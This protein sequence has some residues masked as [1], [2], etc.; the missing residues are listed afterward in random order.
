VLVD[1]ILLEVVSLQP[2]EPAAAATPQFSGSPAAPQPQSSN[3]PAIAWWILGA[4]TI[5]IALLAGL[6]L[7]IK[8]SW[9]AKSRALAPGSGEAALPAAPADLE[10]W[11][12][13]AAANAVTPR[14]EQSMSE[15]MGPELTEFAKQALVQGLYTQRNALLETQR[16]AQEA[17]AELEQRLLELQLPM[18]ERIRAYEARIAELEKELETRGAEMR[19]LTHATLLLVRQKLEQEREKE[20]PRFN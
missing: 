1:N 3:Y 20:G 18:P 11:R 19:E 8:N 7:I 17:L 13:R 16:K 9:P 4:L 15:K 10:S 14:P 2:A 12:Q 6:L 5:I